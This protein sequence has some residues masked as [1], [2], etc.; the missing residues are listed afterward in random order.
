MGCIHSVLELIDRTGAVMRGA[1]MHGLGLNLVKERLMRRSYGVV[2]QPIFRPGVD[3][4]N[5]RFVDIVGVARC[6]DVM[7][8]YARKVPNFK[9]NSNSNLRV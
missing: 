9:D 6:R 4:Q 8:W 3:P 7:D 1:V 5:R 2:S